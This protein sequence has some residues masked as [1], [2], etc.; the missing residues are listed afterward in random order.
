MIGLIVVGI[1]LFFSE[2]FGIIDYGMF[3][4]LLVLAFYF[5]KDKELMFYVATFICVM[6]TVHPIRLFLVG[7]NQIS[8][9]ELF[10]I[11][12]LFCLMFYNGKKGKLNLKW[13]FYVFYPLHLVLILVLKLC[14]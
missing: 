8:I 12:A 3:G 14:I 10:S 6:L 7:G 2:I 1:F 5:I 11:V 4:V 9:V 13:A